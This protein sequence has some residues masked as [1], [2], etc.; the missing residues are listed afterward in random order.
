ML[1]LFA[2]LLGFGYSY[3]EYRPRKRPVHFDT[4]VK[5][6]PAMPPDVAREYNALVAAKIALVVNG[7]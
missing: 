2:D 1:D 5:Q 6:S 4:P 3:A 7:R